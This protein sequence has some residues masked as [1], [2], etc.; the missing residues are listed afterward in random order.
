MRLCGGRGTERSTAQECVNEPRLMRDRMWQ[1]ISSPQSLGRPPS[2]PKLRS[3]TEGQ[4]RLIRSAIGR[5]PTVLGFI[6][7]SVS[8]IRAIGSA[9]AIGP[10]IAPVVG[11][12]TVPR[13]GRICIGRRSSA[14]NNRSPDYSGR[15]PGPKATSGLSWHCCSKSRQC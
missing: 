8:A 13:A 2:G 14:G 12:I 4:Q 1:M 11:S 15:Q 6:V 9:V 5:L 7:G 3:F 10:I